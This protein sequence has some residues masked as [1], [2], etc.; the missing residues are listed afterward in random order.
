MDVAVDIGLPFICLLGHLSLVGRRVAYYD[1]EALE[2]EIES[3]T[4]QAG[5][6]G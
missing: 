1:P 5:G 3:I 2:R 4:M 6:K